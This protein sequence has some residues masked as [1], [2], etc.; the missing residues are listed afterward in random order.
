MR[1]SKQIE[2]RFYTLDNSGLNIRFEAPRIP[3]AEPKIQPTGHISNFKHPDYY[4]N[5]LDWQDWRLCYKG[6]REFVERYI[7]KFTNREDIESFR[8]RK[9]L[10]PIPAFAKAN[11][12]EIKNSIF[13]R[14]IDVSR[15]NG[16]DTYN[17]CMKGEL[18][19]VDLKGSTMNSF[20]GER[21][22]PELLTMK[23]VGLY[24]ENFSNVGRTIAEKG[25]K[26]PYFTTYGAEQIYNWA[27][28][29][30]NQLTAVLLEHNKF[31]IDPDNGLPIENFKT[32]R[33]LYLEDNKVIVEEYHEDSD[34][35]QVSWTL[36]IPQIPF[37]VFEISDS[38]LRDISTYQI[39]LANISS[40]DINQ[41]L[42]SNF[43]FYTEKV[44]ARSRASHLLQQKPIIA[45]NG[46]ESTVDPNCP[47]PNN[48][49]RD[50]TVGAM[51]G[52]EYTDERPG[53]IA[54][55]TEPLQASMKKQD[56]L[57]EEIRTLIH[58][59][60]SNIKARMA[61]A[62]SKAKDDQGLEAGLAA[63]G[64]ELEHGERQAAQLW[65]LYENPR[66]MSK[67][68]VFYPTRW[69]LKT[70][71][72]IRKEVEHLVEQRDAAPSIKFKKT[73]TKQIVTTILSNKISSDELKQIYAEI[74]ASPVVDSDADTIISV[75]KAGLLDEETGATS[76][77]F[78]KGTIDKARTDRSNR[79]KEVQ[80]AQTSR[81][82]ARGLP[83]VID[84]DSGKS[85]KQGKRQRGPR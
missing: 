30:Y 19:G 69:S 77:G 65:D 22:L 2:K 25:N 36:N 67:V 43:P 59:N 27:F 57:K 42:K 35:V 72:E 51:H 13:E 32:F 21:I 11:V 33:L 73:I 44:D 71:D 60:L 16:S 28:D 63:L 7:V 38:L 5:E 17:R 29:Q 6:G 62:E 9:K 4:E 53:F 20:I 80:A 37:V 52:R 18:G 78:P 10:T 23:R 61:S 81:N 79:I 70:D 58:L 54:P 15:V 49:G 26:H 3:I 1:F 14:M 55:P 66:V 8:D 47:Q 74:D 31:L 85:E 50:I 76:L 48:N 40:S 84:D 45:P 12:N 41:I 34:L 68:Q 46:P 64:L 39:A 82:A 56:S 75:V 24:V 83:T